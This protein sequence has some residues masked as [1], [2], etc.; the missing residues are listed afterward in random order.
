MKKLYFI[1]ALLMYALF[2]GVPQKATA[3]FD[4][5]VEVCADSQA[6]VDLVDTVFLAG[7]NPQSVANITFYGDPSSVGYFK[8]GYFLGFKRPQGIVMTN[9]KADDVDKSNECSPP[10]VN[11]N[12]NNNGVDGDPDLEQLAGVNSY[13]G[14]II[15]F[16]FKPTAD[17]VRFNYVFASEEYHDYVNVSYNDMFGFFLSGPGIT[18]P[19]SND[20]DNIALVPGTNI[21]V[22]IN[23]INFGSGGVTCTGKPNGCKNCEWFKDNSQT[24]DP[25]FSKF[26]YDGLTKSLIAK[27]GM[28]QCEWYHI[29][30]AISDGGDHLRFGCAAGR[31]QFQCRKYYRKHGILTP[32]R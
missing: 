10:V 7:V 29:K 21:G 17:T 30:L 27:A 18:G 1:S 4:F 16:D 15:E 9:G 14:C 3:Q 25:A 31:W 19:F 11:A 6:V 5:I 32:D 13:D 23:T 20:A 24:T 22:S 28:E 2:L 8:G 12:T 26:V